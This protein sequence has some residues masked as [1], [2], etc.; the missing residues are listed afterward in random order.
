[1]HLPTLLQK[2]RTSAF[3]RWWMN[4][5]LDWMIPF[6]APHGFRVVPMPAGGIRVK[7][8]YWRVNRNHI[9]GIHACAMATAAEMCSGL[10]VLEHLDP[11][12]YR[13]IMRSLRM[14]YHYQAKRPAH[15]SCVPLAEDIERQVLAPLRTSDTADYTSTVELHDRDGK[16]LATGTIT[17]QVKRWDKVRTKR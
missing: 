14:E 4:H 6:N 10:S 17:W 7:I 3:T 11:K 16:H 1:M 8:P 5:V 12:T 13:L 2:A 15:A 9:K